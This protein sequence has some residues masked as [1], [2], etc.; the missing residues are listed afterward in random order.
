RPEA[1]DQPDVAGVELF[2]DAVVQHEQAALEA[3]AGWGLPPEGFG[4]RLVAV[5]KAGEGSGG[6]NG[7]RLCVGLH[8]GGLRSRAQLGGL[9][10]EVDVILFGAARR[11]HHPN[12][13]QPNPPRN[14]DTTPTA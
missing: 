11:V 3:D 14:A 13:T 10:Q 5:Q 4:G 7:G 2:E 9:Y 12:L 6:R 8:T 1:A